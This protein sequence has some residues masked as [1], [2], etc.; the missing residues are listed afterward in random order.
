M[1]NILAQECPKYCIGHTYTK[2]DWLYTLKFKFNVH[3]YCIWRSLYLAI[4]CVN[5]ICKL[6]SS[7]GLH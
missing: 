5:H 2:N 4:I 3:I 1:N 7:L 6:D